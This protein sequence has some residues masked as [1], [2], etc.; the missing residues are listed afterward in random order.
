MGGVRE[1]ELGDR[2]ED[3]EAAACVAMMLEQVVEATTHPGEEEEEGQDELGEARGSGLKAHLQLLNKQIED[4]ED[5]EERHDDAGQLPEWPTKFAMMN[6][7]W[8]GLGDGGGGEEDADPAGKG[9][10]AQAGEEVRRRLEE[11]GFG[12]G[13]ES[14]GLLEEEAVVYGAIEA[15]KELGVSLKEITG[16][17]AREACCVSRAAV[18]LQNK[19]RVVRVRGSTE[20]LYVAAK[21][22]SPW[23][24]GSG[25]EVARREDGQ[26]AGPWLSL[27]GT[28]NTAFIN[29]LR[30]S[31]LEQ[32][33]SLQ[34]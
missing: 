17:L 25:G 9:G 10:G 31:I 1:W 23:S 20:H 22:A 21:H 32:V 5:G 24:S 26:V 14:E 34:P 28:E 15:A 4:G 30:A 6:E 8:R 3:G 29:G 33:M 27:A 12:E 13:A 7:Q 2:A 19:K 11:G 16:K 18:R